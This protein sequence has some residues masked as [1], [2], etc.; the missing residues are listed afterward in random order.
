MVMRRSLTQCQSAALPRVEAVVVPSP[1]AGEGSEAFPQMMMGEGGKPLDLNPSP[2]SHC[3]TFVLPS[4][5][6]GEGALICAQLAAA[7][8]TTVRAI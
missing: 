4:P 7:L 8:L 5:A 1:L 2:S 6:R 3:C